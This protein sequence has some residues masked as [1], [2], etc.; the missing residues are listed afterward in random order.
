MKIHSIVLLGLILLFLIINNNS[1]SQDTFSIV[2]VDPVTGQVG[3]AGA[4]CI[5]GSI[6]ISDVHPG[7]VV[8]HTQSYWNAANQNYARTLMNMGLSPQQIIDSLIMHDAQSNPSIRQYGIVDLVDSGRSAAF[9]GSNCF[10]YKNHIL[11]PTYAIQGNI[12]LGQ[13]ILDSMEARF[14]NTPGTLADKLMAALQGA[15]VPGADTRCLSNGTSSK[16][17]F[18]RVAKMHDTTSTLYL[19]LNVN[20]T[21]F[22]VEPID[23]L[24]VLYNMWLTTNVSNYSNELPYN[25]VLYQNFP[26][27]FNPVTYIGYRLKNSAHVKIMVYDVLGKEVITLVN[28]KQTAGNFRVEFDAFNQPS[29]VYIYN[30]Y[31]NGDIAG[32][33][34]MVLLK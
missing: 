10:D 31:I 20:N 5:A 23:S 3:S 14:L 26:N 6:I 28:R 13:Q 1:L 25:Y 8:I 19:H 22:G 7:V 16:S 11:G 30:L 4:S 32:T 34:R 17:A 29:G 27:P 9:T 18:I 33:K 15:K 21:P 2:A 12:L 24:Q